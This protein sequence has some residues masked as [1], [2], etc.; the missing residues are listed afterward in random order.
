MLDFC[1]CIFELRYEFWNSGSNSNLEFRNLNRKKKEKKTST[2][3]GPKSPLSTQ[4]T[5][6]PQ[7]T[8][9]VRQKSHA[10]ALGPLTSV[11]SSSTSRA[12]VG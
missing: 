4:I 7:P 12:P 3:L 11:P 5:L 2:T 9:T 6:E 10:D 8:S 1:M